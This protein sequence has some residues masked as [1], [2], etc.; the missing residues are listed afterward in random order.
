MYIMR[1]LIGSH[2]EIFMQQVVPVVLASDNNQ[3][4]AMATVMTSAVANANENTFYNFFC[5]LHENVTPENKERL[6]SVANNGRCAVNLVS[7]DKYFN[8]EKLSYNHSTGLA[9]TITTPTLYRLKIPS[10][11]Q[12]FDKIVYVDT[13]IVIR[14]DLTDLYNF[15]IQENFIAGVPATWANEKA[16]RKK[17]MGR[18]KIPSMEYYVNCGVLLMNLKAMRECGLEEKFFDFIQQH[19][20]YGLDGDQL[21]LNYTCHGRIAFL[22]CRYNVTASN[23]KHSSA[24][25]AYYPQKAIDEAIGNPTIFHWTGADKPWKYYDVTLAHEWWQ[26]YAKSPFGDLPL[27]RF[28]KNDFFLKLKVFLKKLF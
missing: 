1:L 4:H 11:L 3:V 20:F 22:P 18:S 2:T 14:G 21:V 17:W 7:M 27:K 28:S 24:M 5:L 16:N 10:V 8:D 15:P 26:Y 12:Q 19:G 23:I 25:K 13:D 6:T 9:H